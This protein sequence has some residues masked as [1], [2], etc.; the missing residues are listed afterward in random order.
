MKVILLQDVKAQGKKG[1]MI[2]VSDGYARNYL[3]PRKLAMEATKDALNA[4]KSADAAQVRRADAEKAKAEELKANLANMPVKIRAKAG[5]SGRLFGSVTTKEIAEELMAQ[6]NIE[7][8]KTKLVLDEP[9]KSFGSFEV[10]AKL[11]TDVTGIIYVQV[12][13]DR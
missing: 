11:Y 13:E 7:I 9:I 2:E 12:F 4:K 3:I 8:P 5:T 10:K 6:Y 1:E